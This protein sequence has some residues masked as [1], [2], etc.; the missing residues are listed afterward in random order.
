MWP[1]VLWP[2][3][4]VAAILVAASVVATRSCGRQCVVWSSIFFMLL[5]G[6][7]TCRSSSLFFLYPDDLVGRRDIFCWLTILLVVKSFLLLLA[8]LLKS[9][10]LHRECNF[11]HEIKR[12]SRPCWR[13]KLLPLL[14]AAFRCFGSLSTFCP[15]RVALIPC[16]FLGAEGGSFLREVE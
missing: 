16:Y 12:T 15:T 14:A 1:P 5:L 4:L 10:Q 7:R 13:K 8:M 6:R 2:P 3:D 9:T 11:V